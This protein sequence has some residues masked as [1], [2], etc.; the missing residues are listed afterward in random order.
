MPEAQ[1][2]GACG[3]SPVAE[4]EVMAEEPVLVPTTPGTLEEGDKVPKKKKKKS[5]DLKK[6]RLEQWEAKAK[7]MAR[8]KHRKLQRDQDF[9]ALQNYRK[10]LP[11]D[12]LDTINGADHS[13]YLL[14]RLTKEGNY[15]NKKSG[16]ERN[17][18][19]VK[20][21]LSRIA[22]YA[23][24]L[25]KRLKEAH[26][27]TK[28]TFLVV[29]GMPSGNKCT[30]EVAIHVL[31]DCKGNAIACDH[32]E[33]GKEQNIGLHL[34]VSPTAM[35]RVTATETYIV[36]GIPTTVRVDNAYCPFCAY[37]CTNH[38]AI[39]K[40]VRMHFQAILVCGWPSCYYVHIESKKMIEHSAEV[41]GMAQARPPWEKGRD[42][43]SGIP[44][45]FQC[46]ELQDES[47]Y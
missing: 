40:H 45:R 32:P 15:I 5:A 9:K 26:Q 36:D 17:L 39:N 27:M 23:D 6:F 41:H 33:Y 37:T 8:V 4:S 46:Y 14:E 25:E 7:E 47:C 1:N 18:M 24:E 11:A 3:D 10:N 34:I 2:N 43:R 31:M 30:L 44:D 35:T 19:S 21:L 29:Q 22:T 42:W 16:K 13:A 38:R 28:A 12:L 20:H